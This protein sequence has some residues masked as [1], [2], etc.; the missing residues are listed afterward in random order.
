M[1]DHS[2][3]NFQISRYYQNNPQYGGCLSKD[4]L[5][6]MKPNGKFYIVNMMSSTSGN[7]SH[8]VMVYDCDP[9]CI[10]YADSYGISAP[11]EII[12]FMKKSGK[13]L[14]YNHLQFQQIN[15]SECGEY[16]IR[17][18]DN[19]LSGRAYN[20]GLLGKPCKQNEISV[21]SIYNTIS[22]KK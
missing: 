18:I 20:D 11:P 21:N 5:T 1:T 10:F 14:R 6:K 17:M 15:S 13:Q 16:A 9:V 22:K 2:L 12:T 19:L 4:Q 7:G 3:T 8:W